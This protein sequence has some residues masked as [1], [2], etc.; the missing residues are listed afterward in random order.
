MAIIITCILQ[1]AG[2]PAM[3]IL[4]KVQ[5]S[6]SATLNGKWLSHAE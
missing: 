1:E 3:Q 6:A 4:V 5:L 2:R